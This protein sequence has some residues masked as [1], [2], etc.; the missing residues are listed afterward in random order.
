[1]SRGRLDGDDSPL[2]AAGIRRQGKLLMTCRALRAAIPGVAAAA[3]GLRLRPLDARVANS[4]SVVCKTRLGK[5][6]RVKG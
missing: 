4:W 6:H 2:S 5:N 1:M 3:K